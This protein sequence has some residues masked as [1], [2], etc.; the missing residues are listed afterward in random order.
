[1]PEFLKLHS[2]NEAR[3][4]FFD[5]LGK[6]SPPS[7]MIETIKSTG[8]VLSEP[9]VANEFLPA[10]T[11]SSMDGY[12]VIAAD[13][14]GASENLPRYLK[15]IGELPMGREP[16]FAIKRGEAALIHTGGMLAEGADAVVILEQSHLTLQGELEVY[17]PVS[18]GE[19]VIFK[20]E[21]VKPGDE[22]I[23]VGKTIR[24]A[25][26]GGLFALGYT[27][28]RVAKKPLF[29]ILSSG[30][31]V[32]PPDQALKPGQVRDINSEALAVLIEQNGGA[33]KIYP[34]IPDNREQ[35]AVSIRLAYAEA[36]AVVITAGS[37]AST[38]DM[39]AEVIQELGKPGILVHG[40]NIRPGKPTILA[41]CDHKPVIGLPG[42]P[43]SALVIAQF[44]M[45]PLVI[46]LQG[47]Y[48]EPIIL[49]I[50]A[51][52]S[53]NLASQAGREEWVPVKLT[54]MGDHLQAEPIFF[55]SNLI[56]QLSKADGL[57]KINA[58]ETGKAAHSEVE[59]LI[60]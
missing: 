51:T 11:R 9:L 60:L 44:F 3:Q 43:I 33:Y 25:E 40:I 2:L 59:V 32:V 45:K 7:E 27:H 12:A 23:P 31:E 18:T 53:I 52:L 19:N 29:A 17:K 36:D 4:I 10:F 37:S 48:N 38:R 54:Q 46:W 28:V 22:V 24:P 35:M 1:M 26:V 8:R 58:D 6:N 50:K 20:G 47:N 34:I 39:T 30:D 41:V 15:F 5:A 16:E 21:D 56:F 49:L 14:F 55:K 42:N 13:T 57:M